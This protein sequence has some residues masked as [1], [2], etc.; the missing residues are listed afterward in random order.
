MRACLETLSSHDCRVQIVTKSALVVRDVDLL[1]KIPSMVALTITTDDDNVA[2]V[3]EPYTPP[4]SER[5][6]AAENL[7]KKGILTAVRIDP[8]IPFI[9]DNPEELIKILASIGVKHITCSTYKVKPD[10]WQR[11]NKTLPIASAKLKPLYFEKGQRIARSTYLPY[12]LRFKLMKR[13][14]VLADK[15]G[16]KFGT[17]REGL[18]QLNTAPCDGSW[19]LNELVSE[20]V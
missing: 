16:L 3:I 4:P 2:R 13:V 19:L 14:A 18:S 7:V 6:K 10:N 15:Y 1:R 20:R 17:C 12:E 9:N 5:L 8:I 11:L